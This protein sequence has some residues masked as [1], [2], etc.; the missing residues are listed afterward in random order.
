MSLT[1]TNTECGS[2]SDHP[3]KKARIQMDPKEHPKQS[4]S[5]K[6]KDEEIYEKGGREGY[7]EAGEKNK[8][9]EEEEKDEQE[10]KEL[11]SDKEDAGQHNDKQE[12]EEVESEKEDDNQ[13]DYNSSIIG[14]ELRSKSQHEAIKIISI[15]RFQVATPID[16]PAELTGDLVLKCQLGKP[17]DKFRKTMKNENI[18]E[19]F[20]KSCFGHFL[21]L[22]ADHT[23]H[24]QMSM[25]YSILKC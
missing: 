9:K 6:N 8:S 18:N 3:T 14:H 15:D 21:E 22:P 24:F 16:D 11:E 12:E 7:I 17:F 4:Q 19:I 1:R 5:G 13:H 25:V 10:E 20:K 2:T 23:A